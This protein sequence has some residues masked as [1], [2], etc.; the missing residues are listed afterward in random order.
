M[1][2]QI[3]QFKGMD[4][5]TSG[6]L[7]E[8]VD[9]LNRLQ[10]VTTSGG[11]RSSELASG[12][13]LMMPKAAQW[14]IVEL[15]QHVDAGQLEAQAER[16]ERDYNA[17]PGVDDVLISSEPLSHVMDHMA[18]VWLAGSRLVS[19]WIPNS[20]HRVPIPCFNW[21][22]AKLNGILISG[23]TVSARLWSDSGSGTLVD[24]GIDVEVNDW[25]LPA[26]ESLAIGTPVVLLQHIVDRKWYVLTNSSATGV[27]GTS[28]TRFELTSSL[29]LGGS[30]SANLVVWDGTNY[31]N[32]GGA[33]T[34]RDYTSPGAW[35]GELGQQGWATT[36][37]DRADYEIVWMER[38][39][40]RIEGTLNNDMGYLTSGVGSVSVSSFF[41]G[42][43]PGSTVDVY[44]TQGRYGAA[45]A[46]AKT[47]ATWNDRL[48]HYEITSCELPASHVR[49]TVT[50]WLATTDASKSVIVRHGWDGMAVVPGEEIVVY[51]QPDQSDPVMYIFEGEQ[52][53]TGTATFDPQLKR[54]WINWVQCPSQPQPD[55]YVS[56][57]QQYALSPQGAE[58][59][60]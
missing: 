24:S 16:M 38:L 22:I 8:L 34:V 47:Q 51:N 31:V 28:L 6:R 58:V 25:Q 3:D 19:V 50:G 33:I 39:A 26:G 57:Q 30:A 59:Y 1:S 36:V 4:P 15:S 43:D 42:L 13:H 11:I 37:G 12:T 17:L 55:S 10:H 54:Y 41:R 27:A 21:H 49:F 32:T 9:T 5:L 44:D 45:L 2:R 46:G 14:D 35:R 53:A 52:G 40:E 60:A 29:S 18:S 7:N 48:N 56:L 23:S 20:Q